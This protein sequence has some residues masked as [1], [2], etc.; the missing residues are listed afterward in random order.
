MLNF[1]ITEYLKQE[2]DD[3]ISVYVNRRSSSGHSITGD[4]YLS[5]S[6]DKESNDAA[7]PNGEVSYGL[8]SKGCFYCPNL[9]T[10]ASLEI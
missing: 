5:T 4:K 3:D 9:I 1:I 10:V 6:R 8:L 2:G 7:N